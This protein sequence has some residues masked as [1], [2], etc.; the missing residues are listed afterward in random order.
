VLEPQK[1]EAFNRHPAHLI[2]THH[3]LCRMDCRHISREDIDQVM[4]NGIIFLNKTDLNDRPCPTFALQGFTKEDEN[5][6]VIFAQC[7][8]ETKVVTC[9]NLHK[10]FECHCSGDEGVSSKKNEY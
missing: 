3:A 2:Y 10:D 8:D 4:Q 6:R 5:I 1:K 7:T 9:Y